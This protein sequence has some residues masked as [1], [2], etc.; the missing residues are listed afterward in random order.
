MKI[1][2]F[3]HPQH[4]VYYIF[5]SD[6]AYGISREDNKPVWCAYSSISALFSAK[7]F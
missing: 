4:G 1:G 7:G 6:G 5:Y 2:S 3:T